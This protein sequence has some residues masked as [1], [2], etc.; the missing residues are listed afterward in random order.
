MCVRRKWSDN[1][2]SIPEVRMLEEDPG[3]IDAVVIEI[4]F[5]AVLN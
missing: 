4:E 5:M 3:V 1:L 2:S